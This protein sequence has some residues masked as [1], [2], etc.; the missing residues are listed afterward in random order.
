MIIVVFCDYYPKGY[1][2]LVFDKGLH[3]STKYYKF[4]LSFDITEFCSGNINI[5]AEVI[6]S[7]IQE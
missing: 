5:D 4:G 2:V 7:T 6:H 1:V 3:K